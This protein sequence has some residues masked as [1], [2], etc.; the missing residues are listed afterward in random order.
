MEEFEIR[1][2]NWV[3]NKILNLEI[4][5]NRY[6]PLRGR[7]YTP[8]TQTLANKKAIINVKNRDNKCFLWS[9]LA[10]L[11]PADKNPQRVSKYKQWE[12]EFDEALSEIEFPVKLSNVSKFA[13]RT[14]MSINIYCY[15]NGCIAPLE[16][17]DKEKEKHVDLLYLKDNAHIH[18]C[19][20]Q[21][22]SRLVKSQVT[23][24]KKKTFLC[25]M[26]LNHFRSEEKLKNHKSYCGVHKSA[27]I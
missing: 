22:L 12:H 9:I 6:N 4:A 18:Y 27:R 24:Y 20:I 17:T 26:C 5:L 14:N 13:K 10:A 25:R 2:S 11:H 23:K 16:V 15:N 1:G 19:L 21:N 3:L 8:L 7:S